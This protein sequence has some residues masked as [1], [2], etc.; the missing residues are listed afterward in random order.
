MGC[1]HLQQGVAEQ[2]W[3]GAHATQPFGEISK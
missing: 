2:V 3:P 1:T